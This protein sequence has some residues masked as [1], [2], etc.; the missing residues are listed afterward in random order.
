MAVT[1]IVL[2][3]IGAAAQPGVA[4]RP[5]Q[6]C[7]ELVRGFTVPG[8]VAHVTA[9]AV[10]PAGTGHPEYCDVRG[11]IEPAVGFQL[12]LPTNTF[13]G[14]YVQYGCGGFCGAVPAAPFADC[15]EPA[16]GDVAVAA[17]DDGHTRPGA[18]P[19]GYG[20]WGAMSQAA[21]NDFFYRAPHV[22]L[23]AAK[24]IIATYYGAPPARSYFTSCSNGGREGLLLAQ[25][26]P[27]DFNGIIAGAPANYFGPL[28]GVYQA[29]L[30]KTNTGP[31]DAPIITSAKLPALHNAVLAACDGLDG[32]LDGQIDDPRQCR[33]DPATLQCADATDQPSC[34]TATQVDAA[35]KLYGGPTDPAGRHLYPGGETYGSELAWNKWLITDRVSG[36]TAGTFADDYLKF[37]GYPI[38]TPHSSLAAFQFTVPEFDRLAPEGVKSNAVSLDLEGFRRAGGKLIIWHG[39]ADQ[40]IPPAGTLDYYERLWQRSGGLPET[41][42]WARLFM[43]P[44]MYHCAGGDRLTEFDPLRELVAWVEHGTAPERIVANQKDDQGR[45]IRSRP[46]FPYPVQARYAGTGSIDDAASFVAAPPPVAPHDTVDWVGADLFSLPAP[47]G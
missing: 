16:G 36:S 3:P 18:D 15:G 24:H 5:I 30:A 23:L 10:V 46:V 25:R 33:F 37:L 4:I 27:T 45:I 20:S 13:S 17:T 31:Q 14:R 38:G 22:L 28:M 34:L 41:Q 29:W 11:Y 47:V 40:A 9:A 8:V 44:A 19:S 43:I 42:Q 6:Q 26:Y 39:W 35:R 32:Q 2:T 7:A 12:K 1:G 21:R